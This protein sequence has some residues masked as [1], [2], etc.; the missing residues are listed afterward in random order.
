MISN[1]LFKASII[2]SGV[3]LFVEVAAVQ[4]LQQI[5]DEVDYMDLFQSGF[6]PRHGTEMAMITLL[7]DFWQE[8]NGGS[9]S[10]LALFV[11]LADF[12]ITDQGNLLDWYQGLGMG[13]T[14]FFWFCSFLQ[15]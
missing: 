15:G 9:A 2:P 3:H 12:N 11:L 5:L 4:Q 6:R 14:V 10:I 13:T 7:D 1:L 8:K